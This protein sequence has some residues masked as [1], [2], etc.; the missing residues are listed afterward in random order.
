M[1][2]HASTKAMSAEARAAT[3][4]WEALAGELDG[5]G[6]AVL[7]RLLAPEECRAIAALYPDERH[8]RS[9]I[10]MARHG[11]GKGEYRYFKYPLP[12]LLGGLRTRALSAPRRRGQCMERSH[13]ARRALSRRACGVSQAVPR[14]R[15]GASDPA[16][17]AVRDGRFQLPPPGPL[18]RPGVP[19]PGRNPALGA[20]GGLHRRRVR[21]HRAEAAHAEPRRGGAAADKAMRS[22]S[23]S[24]IG[25]CEA[26][27][28]TTA[29]I[30]AMA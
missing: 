30:S 18:R 14:R 9:H 20:R 8:F 22:P 2:A 28:G 4:D 27:R 6:C 1:N 11:F 19:D 12:D 13:G 10:V 16:A 25:R 21:P 15:P 7:P 23:L 3:Y 26:R 29:S 24:T 17:A 5:Y